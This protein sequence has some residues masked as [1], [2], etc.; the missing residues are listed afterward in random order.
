MRPRWAWVASIRFSNFPN[1]SIFRSGYPT[2]NDDLPDLGHGFR[3]AKYGRGKSP[4]HAKKPCEIMPFA[5]ATDA[6]F[7]SRPMPGRHIG[8]SNCWP[9]PP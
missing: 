3:H 7:M 5:E 9:L 6:Q 1:T 2:I 4:S 8:R